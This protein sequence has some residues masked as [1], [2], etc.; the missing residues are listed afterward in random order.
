MKAFTALGQEEFYLVVLPAIYWCVNAALGVRI[1]CM[2]IITTSFNSMLKLVFTSPRPYW[3]DARVKGIVTEPSFGLPSGHAMN[4]TGLW[5]Y[6]S[7]QV[8]KRW[9]S[10]LVGVIVFMI[11]LSRI[12]LGVHFTSDV[13][14]GWLA[15]GLL[16][17]AFLKWEKPVSDW[18][19]RMAVQTQILWAVL[20]SLGIIAVTLVL[21][22]IDSPWNPPA[23]WLAN[24]PDIAP[25][26]PSGPVS[27]AGVWLGFACGLAWLHKRHGLLKPAKSFKLKVL[28]Y[29]IGMV[30]TG[31]IYAGLAAFFPHGLDIMAMGLRYVRYAFIGAWVGAFAPL[32][33]LY[34]KV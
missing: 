27:L 26:D 11:G 1:G 20:S 17:A 3:I 29:V 31:V 23:A 21:I 22:A 6:F 9:F 2:L 32:V 30:G 5:G 16:L 18:I 7:S 24:A 19:K 15:G 28:R 33:F 4:S 14:A 8:K 34:L 10:I 12:A 13:L 25:L